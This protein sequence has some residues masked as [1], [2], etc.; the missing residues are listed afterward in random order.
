VCLRTEYR[1]KYLE[2]REKSKRKMEIMHNE[3]PGCLYS[4]PNI[5]KRE[6]IKKDE[7]V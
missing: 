3:E 2:L 1:K 5:T 4:S 6:Q 7:I